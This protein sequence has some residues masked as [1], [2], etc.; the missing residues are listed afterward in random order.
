MLNQNANFSFK[1]I[2]L[3]MLFV[4]CQWF[5]SALNVL[6]YEDIIKNINMY[7]IDKYIYI[8]YNHKSPDWS[9]CSKK[10]CWPSCEVSP[11]PSCW[12]HARHCL[13]AAK[14][15]G[16]LSK[17]SSGSL[18]TNLY[19]RSPKLQMV[20]NVSSHPSCWTHEASLETSQTNHYNGSKH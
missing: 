10:Y 20:R 17:L 15:H 4:N 14:P 13:W 16:E 1:K 11:Q 3:K 9:Y 8:I 19:L 7:D 12:R 18:T 2:H 6:E 5:F